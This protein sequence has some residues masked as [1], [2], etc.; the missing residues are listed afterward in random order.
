MKSRSRRNRP[1]NWYRSPIPERPP[2]QTVRS[3]TAFHGPQC[4]CEGIAPDRGGRRRRDA[5]A[6]DRLL[7]DVQRAQGSNG[8]RVVGVRAC[9][10][11]TMTACAKRPCAQLVKIEIPVDGDALVDDLADSVARRRVNRHAWDEGRRPQSD[12]AVDE[13]PALESSSAA[14]KGRLEDGLRRCAV[15][16]ALDFE[17]RQLRSRWCRMRTLYLGQRP[18]RWSSYMRRSEVSK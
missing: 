16:A 5:V 10:T 14:P 1:S 8:R 9:L 18:R 3:P 4:R 7:P 2:R 11:S 13:T 6:A 12:S 17:K 15:G